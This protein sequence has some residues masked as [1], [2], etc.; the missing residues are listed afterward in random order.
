MTDDLGRVAEYEDYPDDLG[1]RVIVGGDLSWKY[2]LVS[3]MT[4]VTSWI[5]TLHSKCW[6]VNL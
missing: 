6:A 2:Q 1:R 5:I 3:H 4:Y